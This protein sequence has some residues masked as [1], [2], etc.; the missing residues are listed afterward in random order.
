MQCPHCKGKGRKELSRAYSLVCGWCDG[1]GEIKTGNT[2]F[3]RIT[4]GPEALAEFIQEITNGCRG[5][6]VDCAVECIHYKKTQVVFCV[7]DGCLEWLKEE[8]KDELSSENCPDT[9]C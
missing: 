6:T 4:A 3:D 5:C 9:G 7:G 2:N 1:T 8:T